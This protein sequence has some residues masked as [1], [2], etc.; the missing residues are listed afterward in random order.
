M[1]KDNKIEIGLDY[2]YLSLPGEP[3][4]GLLPVMH[5]GEVWSYLN[6]SAHFFSA[7]VSTF[8]TVYNCLYVAF[9]NLYLLQ[10]FASTWFCVLSKHY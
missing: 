4:G 2:E 9:N 8:I 7:N 1:G 6:I 5:D 10:I 3:V